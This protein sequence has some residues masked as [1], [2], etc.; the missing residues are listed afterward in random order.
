MN[1]G[2]RKYSNPVLRGLDDKFFELGL[3]DR[4]GGRTV[5]L[6]GELKVR[7]EEMSIRIIDDG[8]CRDRLQSPCAQNATASISRTGSGLQKTWH[9]SWTGKS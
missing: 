4:E 1:E 5:D 3:R 6:R 2:F 9:D 8:P 7:G